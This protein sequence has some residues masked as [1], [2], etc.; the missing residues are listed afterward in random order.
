MHHVTFI[1]T[2]RW[3]AILGFFLLLNCSWSAGQT[4]DQLGT[5]FKKLTVFEVRPGIVAL[6]TF[7]NDGN[8]CRM[9]IEK[10]R[11]LDPANSDLGHM[12]PSAEVDPL[13]DEVVPPSER[14]K[15]SK[16]LSTD[17]WISGG[18]AFIKQDYENVS[19]GVYGTSVPD[20]PNG[21]TLIVIIWRNRTC[22]PT[23]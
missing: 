5:R 19:V 1:S 18:G 8:V 23:R 17:S 22:P 10:M 2:V 15:A 12:I 21:A 11:S 16:Y 20:K 14:G 13:V 9:T 6:S 3:F 4:E 7:S